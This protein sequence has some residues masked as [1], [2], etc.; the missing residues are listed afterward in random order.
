V[1]E[2]VRD[3]GFELLLVEPSEQFRRDRDGRAVG[4]ETSRE[5]VRRP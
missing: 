2:L 4:T 1:C 3:D 5:R